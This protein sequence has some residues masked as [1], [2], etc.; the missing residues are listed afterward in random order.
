MNGLLEFIAIGV[1]HIGE[2]P[3]LNRR[4]DALTA[5]A[6]ICE[7]SQLSA[8]AGELRAAAENIRQA[9]QSQLRLNELFTPFTSF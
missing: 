1:R 7:Q 8:E 2:I 9:D 6:L 3:D 5:A 4:A